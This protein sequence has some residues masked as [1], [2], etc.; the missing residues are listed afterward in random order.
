MTTHVPGEAAALLD[1]TPVFGSVDAIDSH[2]HFLRDVADDCRR[3]AVDV[4]EA[5]RSLSSETSRSVEKVSSKLSGRLFP[6]LDTVCTSADEAKAAFDSYASAVERIHSD[7]RTVTRSV[8]DA[9]SSIRSQVA[10][11]EEIAMLI[12]VPA[13]YVWHIAAP[14]AMPEPRLG[15]NAAGLDGGQEEIARQQLRAIHESRWMLAASIWRSALDD[16]ESGRARWSN[17]IDERRT[18]EARLSSALEN[19][20]IG[21]LIS[22]SGASAVS[23]RFTIAAGVVGELWGRQ[24]D[25]PGVENLNRL[26]E[27]DLTSAEVATVWEQLQDDGVDTDALLNE[28][29]FELAALDGLPFSAMDQAGRAALAYALDTDRP[30]HL[31]EAFQRMGFHP[32]DRSMEDFRTDLEAV[33]DA[34]RRADANRT[35]PSEAVQLVAFGQHDGAATAGISMGDLDTASTVGVFV[36]GM[37]SDVRGLSDSFDAFRTIREGETDTAMVTWVG[38]RSPGMLEETTQHRADAGAVRLASFL[39]GIAVQRQ[40]NPIDRFAVLGHSYGTNVVSEA[41]KLVHERLEELGNPV[42]AFVTVGSAG[43]R[44]GTEAEDLGVDEIHA[45]SAEG[46]NIAEAIGQHVHFRS[47][48][49]DGGGIYEARVDPRDLEGSRVFSSEQSSDGKAVTM[50]NLVS[51]VDWPI[52]LQ[53]APDLDGTAASEEVGYLNPKSTTVDELGKIMRN[54]WK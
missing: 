39:E 2:A 41:L 29:G 1:G 25:A 50:H 40:D 35:S 24:T 34:L 26:L 11:I 46:D 45:T 30:E 22:V 14:A 21:Q 7:A 31:E 17:L 13:A 36:S 19:T 53:W 18:A 47:R 9:L 15:A 3:S 28:Y 42:D 6:G 33:R 20:P 51:P 48:F 16:I 8:D 4:R 32:G 52:W 49:D 43:L 27:G 38:Y 54:E 5:W 44:Y 10:Q 12:R 37:N 23:Q